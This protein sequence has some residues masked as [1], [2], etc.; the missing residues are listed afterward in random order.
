M[1]AH[2]LVLGDKTALDALVGLDST[3]AEGTALGHRDRA[4][5]DLY[6]NLR[7]NR[8]KEGKENLKTLWLWESLMGWRGRRAH[9]VQRGIAQGISW[10]L[11]L[12]YTSTT[13]AYRVWRGQGG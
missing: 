11:T 6:D 2:L 5:E 1:T 12:P 13:G 3:W 8:V 9:L 10:L 7:R 4:G